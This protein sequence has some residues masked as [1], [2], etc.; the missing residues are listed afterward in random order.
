MRRLALV[1]LLSSAMLGLPAFV[2]SASAC[3]EGV[4]GGGDCPDPGDG[5]E[6][7]VESDGYVAQVRAVH[8]PTITYTAVPTPSPGVPVECDFFMELGVDLGGESLPFGWALAVEHART[9]GTGEWWS[10][11]IRCWRVGETTL[12]PG[13]PR[14]FEPPEPPNPPTPDVVEEPRLPEYASDAIPFE[15]AMPELSPAV[16]QV[17]GVPTW[18]AVTTQLE[19]DAVVANAGPLSATARAEFRNVRWDMGDGTPEIVCTGADVAVVYDPDVPEDEQSTN[20]FHLYESNGD[21]A[22]VELTVTA[23]MTWDI[24]ASTSSDPVE[25]L[26][27]PVTRTATFVVNVRELQAVID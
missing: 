6:E 12:I 9:L 1:L 23:T 5:D 24:W 4:A 10:V 16:D 14:F 11:Q 19:Y 13:F 18:L 25:R 7:E 20:C 17:V 8:Q 3:D 27:T 15:P 2:G 22:Q 21:G 26:I